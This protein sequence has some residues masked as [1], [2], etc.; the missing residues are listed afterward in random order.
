[1]VKNLLRSV[2]AAAV[3]GGF[4]WLCSFGLEQIGITS[5]LIRTG[6]PIL[7]GVV[8]YL[9]AAIKFRAITKEDCLLLPKGKKIAALL[10]LK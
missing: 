5:R 4:V 6:A 1:M 9:V 2:I 7:V 8:V 10:K 3:M